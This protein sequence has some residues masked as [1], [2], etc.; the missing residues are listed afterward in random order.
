MP[1]LPVGSI[2]LTSELARTGQA[3]SV[4][5]DF[6]SFK[7]VIKKAIIDVNEA[8]KVTQ[9]DMLK[10]AMGEVDDLH[11]IMLNAAKAE[12]ALHTLVQVRNKAIDAYNEIMR[13][14]L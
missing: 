12:L 10:L 2:N 1:V 5:E 6:V 3:G 9:E 14:S 7:D 8:Q 11:T 4:S 13:I